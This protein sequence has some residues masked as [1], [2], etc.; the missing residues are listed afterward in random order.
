MNTSIFVVSHKPYREVRGNLYK[1]IQVGR[2]NTGLNISPITDDSGENIAEKN[3]NYCELTAFFWLWKNIH[4]ID[5]IGICHYRRYFTTNYYLNFSPFF[6]NERQ[7]NNIL[8][9]YDVILPKPTKL[10]MTVRS[11]Y[12]YCDGLDKDLET[13]GNIIKRKCPQYLK[14]F[15]TVMTTNSASYCNMLI[16]SKKLFDQYCTWLFDILFEVEKETNME[17]Y[18]KAQRR[19]FGYISEI[20]L[21]VWVMHNKLRVKYMDVI[22]TETSIKYRIVHRIRKEN[23]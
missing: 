18:T 11:Y 10:S 4:D 7:V 12:S 3:S 1:T 17:G 13:T 23:R 21:N 22:N 2:L 16:T 5:Y 19:V 9:N 8:K 20:L 15:E 6:V 14:D